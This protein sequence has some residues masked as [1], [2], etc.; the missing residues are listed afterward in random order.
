MRPRVDVQPA[1]GNQ[2]GPAIVIHAA[3]CTEAGVVLHLPPDV[4]EDVLT[5][6]RAVIERAADLRPDLV[7]GTA[8][9]L[10]QIPAERSQEIGEL[11]CVPAVLIMPRDRCARRAVIFGV[12]LVLPEGVS[13]LSARVAVAAARP[14]GDHFGHVV[15]HRFPP[16]R[17]RSPPGKEFIGS[18]L[19]RR[20]AQ[21][22]APDRS[23]RPPRTVEAPR[24]PTSVLAT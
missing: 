14:F 9:L 22:T 23:G 3:V 7:P 6:K 12:V 1:H 20:A 2:P 18:I 5:A 17:H 15:S 21:Y 13:P 16:L 8:N 4:V 11:L 10:A 24:G 19:A